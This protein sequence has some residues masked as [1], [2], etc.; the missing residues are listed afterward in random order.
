[1]VVCNRGVRRTKKI[2]CLSRLDAIN[3]V[4]AW[5]SSWPFMLNRE[6]VIVHQTTGAW[7]LL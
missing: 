6:S 1:V 5:W 3:G 7:V 2:L 4:L